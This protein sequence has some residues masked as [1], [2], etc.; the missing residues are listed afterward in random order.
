MTTEEDSMKRIVRI[1][2]PLAIVLMTMCAFADVAFALPVIGFSE[3]GRKIN[4][5]LSYD[6]YNSGMEDVIYATGTWTIGPDDQ[7]EANW[8]SPY[9]CYEVT[10][11]LNEPAVEGEAVQVPELD[12][13]QDK[14]WEDENF[15]ANDGYPGTIGEIIFQE[16]ITAISSDFV[17]K[18]FTENLMSCVR[19]LHTVRF[20]MTLQEIGYNAFNGCSSLHTV[21]T[22]E[23]GEGFNKTG[24]FY[25]SPSIT[26]VGQSAF[27]NT[28]PYVIHDSSSSWAIPYNCYESTKVREV[29]LDG[30]Y[31][32]INAEAFKYCGCLLDLTISA[33]V[34][35]IGYGA[36]ECCPRLRGVI[37]P[38]TVTRIEAQTKGLDTPSYAF[39][40]C[41][42][43]EQITF[44]TNMEYIHPLAF[45]GCDNL[46]TIY[47]NG[48]EEDLSPN[49][50]LANLKYTENQLLGAEI[51][52]SGIPIEVEKEDQKWTEPLK[53]TSVTY[54]N[55]PKPHAVVD[56]GNPVKYLYCTTPYGE[57]TETVPVNAGQYYV[58]A[59]ASK[60]KYYNELESAPVPFTIKKAK[61][62]IKCSISGKTYCVG[63]K[64]S[65]KYYLTDS[66]LKNHILI[67]ANYLIKN[68][69]N[70]EQGKDFIKFT[71]C[72]VF[73]IKL[74]VSGT[75]NV[76]AVDTVFKATVK[77]AKPAISKLK[78]AKKSVKLSWGKA[79]GAARY[80][81]RYA[82]NSKMK[83]AKTVT[84]QYSS[85]SATVK[86]LSK[87]KKYYFQIRAIGKGVDK[88]T[89]YSNWSA[90]KSVTTKKK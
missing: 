76:E 53:C 35:T 44:S 31:E 17:R 52:F 77:P 25:L 37:L 29:I 67:D 84:K 1:A 12:R 23:F 59:V 61:P 4:D 75:D 6:I 26:Y 38:D 88:K 24:A 51:V 74:C 20:P 10:I 64:A 34:K 62:V 72:G 56:T 87:G 8:T 41:E 57:Y 36:F 30:S 68:G 46:K 14:F 21:S 69:K 3:Y 55:Q 65:F 9:T 58:K 82:T 47:I 66:R 90:V 18:P 43:L 22:G 19:G 54:P 81:I 48:V 50:D 78:P 80:E 27:S 85:L 33:P 5:K 42:Q 32:N 83:D 45:R 60:S 86:N 73:K 40:L 63:D 15:N 16:G 89:Y 70:G 7:W 11:Y 49:L 39:G 79:K 2:I 71:K 28:R 13:W